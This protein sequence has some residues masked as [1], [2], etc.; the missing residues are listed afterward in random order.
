VATKEVRKT[1]R[2]YNCGHDARWIVACTRSDVFI[3]I[4]A[5]VVSHLVCQCRRRTRDHRVVVLSHNEASRDASYI[6]REPPHLIDYCSVTPRH[7]LSADRYNLTYRIFGF[8]L[9]AIWL[10]QGLEL[11][12]GFYPGVALDAVESTEQICLE[13]N[14]VIAGPGPG[15]GDQCNM[16]QA[17]LFAQH[18]CIRRARCSR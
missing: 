17:Y 12:P 18:Y 15:P 3:V 14:V 10:L 5:K 1:N 7:L 6:Y 13:K 11:S 4:E 9:T 8:T 16:F 2:P